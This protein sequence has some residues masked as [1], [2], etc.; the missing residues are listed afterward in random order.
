MRATKVA[1]EAGMDIT[2][3]EKATG[4]NVQATEADWII[5]ETE[6]AGT[7][8]GSAKIYAHGAPDNCF[9]TYTEAKAA[10]SGATPAPG[11]LPKYVITATGC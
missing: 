10:V 1:L 3:D 7:T 9:L 4:T 6:V 5:V 11:E 2:F 8:A